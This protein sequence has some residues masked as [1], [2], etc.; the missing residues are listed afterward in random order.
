MDPAWR[1][2]AAAF[3]LRDDWLR[4]ALGF[5]LGNGSALIVQTISHHRILE[6]QTALTQIIVVQNWFEELKRDVASERSKSGVS[7]KAVS[8]L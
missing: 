5:R 2:L 7:G 1:P 3:Q 4:S 8:R 6:N